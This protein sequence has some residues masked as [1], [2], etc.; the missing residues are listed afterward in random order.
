VLASGANDRTIWL[1]DVET[2][3]PLSQPLT[4]HTHE[5]WDV[6]FSPTLDTLASVS[7][8]LTVRL[9]SLDLSTWRDQVCRA[10]GRDLTDAE[11][12]QFVDSD[13]W[14]QRLGVTRRRVACPATP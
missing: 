11:W 5:V 13:S 3:L 2:R 10:V 8:D 1:W 7:K 4:G 12:R 14:L 6:A 9:W